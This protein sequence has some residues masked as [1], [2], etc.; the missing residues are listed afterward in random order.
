MNVKYKLE[1]IVETEFRMDYDFDYPSMDYEKARVLVGHEINPN[2]DKDLVV[3]T[4]R[5][6]I[7]YGEEERT[8]ASNSIMMTFGLSPIK[9]IITLNEDGTFVT[10]SNLV[11]ETFLVAAIGG[12]RGVM[13]KNLKGTPLDTY[14]IPLI[15]IEQ[16]RIKQTD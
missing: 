2:M 11:V 15:P 3:I 6:S 14:F 1:S 7:V 5:A 9:E 8:L 4:A 16:L 13:M 12:L 10:R